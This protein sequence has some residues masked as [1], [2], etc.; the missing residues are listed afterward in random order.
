[1][2]LFIIPAAGR[3]GAGYSDKQF[4]TYVC[5]RPTLYVTISLFNNYVKLFVNFLTPPL[6]L[7]VTRFTTPDKIMSH[8]SF[9]SPVNILAADFHRTVAKSHNV[10]FTDTLARFL[11]KTVMQ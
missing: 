4:C 2:Y 9:N 8:Y 10:A 6:S 5:T 3:R 7:L 11:Q 1:M